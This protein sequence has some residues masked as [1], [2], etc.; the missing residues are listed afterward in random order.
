[1]I[2]PKCAE[3][4]TEITSWG[5]AFGGNGKELGY[6]IA[7]RD[8]DFVYTA[9]WFHSPI[10][11]CARKHVNSR[12]ADTFSEI[13]VRKYSDEGKLA[14]TRCLGGK[15]NDR[16]YSIITDDKGNVLV[17][18]YFEDR[19]IVN[20][21]KKVTASGG[22]EVFILKFTSK[23][24]V[25]WLK[26]LDGPGFDV[27]LDL[28]VTP[29]GNLYTSGW[30]QNEI[31][32]KT[33]GAANTLSAKGGFDF[34]VMKLNPDGGLIW[35]KSFGSKGYDGAV[36]VTADSTSAVYITG[37]FAG[38]TDFDPGAT[39]FRLK[40]EGDS[41]AFVLKLASSGSFEWAQA[42]GGKSREGSNAIT[43][44]KK[45]N[46]YTTGYFTD[47]LLLDKAQ[48]AAEGGNDIFIQKLNSK[49][50]L[51]WVKRLGGDGQDRGYGI[52]SHDSSVWITGW[53]NSKEPDNKENSTHTQLET[54]VVQELALN[55]KFKE[56]ALLRSDQN[57]RGY[58]ITN[59]NGCL[60]LTGHFSD[61]AILSCSGAN[62]IV[63]EG[64]YKDAYIIKRSNNR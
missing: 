36:A 64:D 13:F 48:I 21:S 28:S 14:W 15:G 45:G 60:Y 38:T 20:E 26:S 50:D 10:R 9:G 37:A 51:K 44:D 55:G 33:K 4:Q 11:T 6:A 35:A 31:H 63:L 23:G 25:V 58:D 32:Y 41:D 27:G 12:T 53:I 8:G 19:L 16:A 56:T 62:P 42:V 40:A 2:F 3:D 30:F 47:T 52:T 18:G 61:S 34:Y 59:Q 46:V 5:E 49:G 1:M 43:L 24:E 54:T 22:K 39:T 29:E 7:Q 17:T 57:N